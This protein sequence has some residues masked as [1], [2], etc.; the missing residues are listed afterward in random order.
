[1]DNEYAIGIDTYCPYNKWYIGFTGQ[2]GTSIRLNGPGC[3]YNRF[4]FSNNI[5]TDIVINRNS[6]GDHNT[7]ICQPP[8]T[9]PQTGVSVVGNTNYENDFGC[10]LVVV[11][12]VSGGGTYNLY[13]TGPSGTVTASANLLAGG[14]VTIFVKD[15]WKWKLFS[16]GGTV[17]YGTASIFAA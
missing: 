8:S 6:A 10:P 12:P 7:I 15:G 3:D 14:P 2:P 16:T 5:S 11:V 4:E 1:M 13:M 9:L 17:N